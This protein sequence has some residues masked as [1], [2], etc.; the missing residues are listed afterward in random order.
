MFDTTVPGAIWFVPGFA[1]QAVIACAEVGHA[2]VAEVAGGA[3]VVVAAGGVVVVVAAGGAVVVVVGAEVGTEAE[4][5][6]PV[7]EM[8]QPWRPP[9]A[10]RLSWPVPVMSLPP[11]VSVIM[12]SSMISFA[13]CTRTR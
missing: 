6:S 8:G 2:V 5:R 1:V 4:V 10:S 12:M 11:L 3:V 7:N 13:G 9:D